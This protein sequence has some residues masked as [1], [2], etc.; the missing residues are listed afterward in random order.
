MPRSIATQDQVR[1]PCDR[2]AAWAVALSCALGIA[3]RD[4]APAPAPAPRPADAARAVRVAQTPPSP[5]VA[6]PVLIDRDVPRPSPRGHADAGALPQGASFLGGDD[7]VILRRI[8]EAPIERIERN[9]GG[10]TISFRVF[11]AGGQRGLFKPQQ[12]AE[13][14]NYRAELA[15]YRMSRLLGLGR[16]PPACGRALPREQLQRVADGSGDA[17]F[18][19]RV[20]TEL[21]GRGELVPGALLYWVP[22]ALEPVPGNE[23]YAALLDATRPL[24]SD[25]TT[26]A[27]DLSTLIL[28][29]FLNDNVDRWSGGNI[30]RQRATATAPTGPTLFMDNG[31]SFSAINDGLGARP[32][33]QATRLEAVQRFSHA[34][35]GALRGLTENSLR[36]AMASDPLG[37]CLSD[38]QVRAVLARRDRIVRHV[39]EV[40]AGGDPFV[41]P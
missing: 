17:E 5:D 27:A 23:D 4:P 38:L 11:F 13:V 10:S 12:R 15:A 14:A 2:R 39:D 40:A 1:Q 36:A 30:L 34:F 41:F 29:D 6:R 35:V 24:P 26:L 16:V 3:C 37:P 8:C 19:R 18:S 32:H 21:L 7:E 20:M 28:F 33:D 9:R 25:R 22:G 31:A